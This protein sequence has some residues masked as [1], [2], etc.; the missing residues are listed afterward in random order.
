MQ[1]TVFLSIS[2]VDVLRSSK[3]TNLWF[4]LKPVVKCPNSAGLVGGLKKITAASV[5]DLLLREITTGMLAKALD[6]I[7]S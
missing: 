6:E 7:F 4:I 2:Y 1:T 5:Y 3:T